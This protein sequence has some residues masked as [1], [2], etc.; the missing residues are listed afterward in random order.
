MSNLAL[1]L[2][3]QSLDQILGQDAAKRAIESFAKKDNWPN[4]F[5]FYGP[6]GTGK[7]TFAEIVAKMIAGEDGDI[8][9]INGSVQNKV[10]DA[11][12]L[13]EIAQ[14]CPFNGRQRVFIVN[15]FHRWTLPAQDAVKDTMEKCPAVWLI[16]TDEP[17]KISPAI[18]SRAS[19]ATFEIKPLNRGQIADL[20]LKAAPSVASETGVGI[21]DFLWSKGVT[22]PREILGVLDQHL[23][24]V[25]LDQCVHGSEHEPL[26]PEIATAV[27]AGNW[28]KTSNLLKQVQTADYRAMVAVVSAKMSWALLD[29]DFGPRADA[30]ATCLVGLGVNQFADGVA[31]SSLKALLY[32]CTRTLSKETK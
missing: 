16:T 10:E 14:S 15:E 2:R 25:P 4:V 9:Q 19:A 20:V 30:I 13:S 32:K 1:D 22:S 28:T 31:Y 18:R 17:D 29:S 12:E 11:R 6:P 27:L 23:A 5:L 7:T 3:P 24:G 26:Y 8:R 21:G